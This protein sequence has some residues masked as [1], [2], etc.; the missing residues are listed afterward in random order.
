MSEKYNEYLK[1]LKNYIES[2]DYK[3]ALSTTE[4]MI[5]ENPLSY[6]AHFF[7]AVS[8]ANLI[9]YENQV[10]SDVVK[11]A[12]EAYKVLGDEEKDSN[13]NALAEIMGSGF[14]NMVS[15]ILKAFEEK[16]PSEQLVVWATTSIE[17]MEEEFRK[18]LSYIEIT[19][20]TE[21]IRKL[22]N[23]I[24]KKVGH[25]VATVW[26]DA[27]FKDYS[28]DTLEGEDKW[29]DPEY[30]PDEKI[31][32]T[33]AKEAM[34]L[35]SLLS[36]SE[37]KI[38]ETTDPQNIYELY[39]NKCIIAYRIA[40]AKAYVFHKELY[41]NGLTLRNHFEPLGTLPDETRKKYFEISKKYDELAYEYEKKI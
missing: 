19:D 26:N 40:N 39:N 7:K 6:E 8:L 1:L 3:G 41:T 37:K 36:F 12:Y 28:R 16:R 32:V 38:N 31:M 24:V 4:K 5:E 22:Q 30:R 14:S 10:V 17:S 27:V 25:T 29:T 35:V 13:R 9:S 2:E 11:S 23:I 15:V 21:Y 34:Y 20:D 33:F 18:A